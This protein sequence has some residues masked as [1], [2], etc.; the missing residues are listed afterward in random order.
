MQNAGLFHSNP[1]EENFLDAA[2]GAPPSQ[3]PLKSTGF[4][5]SLVRKIAGKALNLNPISKSDI[6]AETH[7]RNRF[8]EAIKRVQNSVHYASTTG[9]EAPLGYFQTR[10]IIGPS[11]IVAGSVYLGVIAH[12][13]LVV[14]EKYGALHAL[15]DSLILRFVREDGKRAG[16][17]DKIIR[18]VVSL[19]REKLP[20]D[21]QGV[22]D[23]AFKRGIKPDRKTSLDFYLNHRIG[24]ARHQ[25]LLA[26][27]LLQKLKGR[28][29]ISGAI[30]IDQDFGELPAEDE[31]L[32]YITSS[33]KTYLFDPSQSV[34]EVIG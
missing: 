16:F 6:P 26:V 12:E 1:T 7:L 34:L 20:Y 21:P 22:R 33:G 3:G 9:P 14:D 19:V 13:A 18:Y 32:I 2:D 23:L 5:K 29:L 8:I 11:N 30:Q 4:F 15:Y 17:E 27:Y 28:G 25:V 24:A 10:P 31:R